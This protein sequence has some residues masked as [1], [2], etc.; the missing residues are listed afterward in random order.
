MKEKKK[1]RGL[2]IYTVDSSFVKNDFKILHSSFSITPF[3]FRPDR[4]KLRNVASL[5]AFL[6][7]HIWKSHFT[8]IWFASTHA[9]L[10]VLF[11]R[12]TG[13]KS[14]I[15]LGGYDVAHLPEL[16]YG[17]FSN[18][19]R[20]FTTRM[21][22]S[23]ATHNIAVSQFAKNKIT[24]RFPFLKKNTTVIY[25]CIDPEMYEQSGQKQKEDIVLTVALVDSEQR[26]RLKG[27]DSLLKVA[28]S[29][30]HIQFIVVG[31]APAIS[32]KLKPVPR[33]MQLIEPLPYSKLLD[34]YRRSKVYCLLSLTESFG[35]SVIEAMVNLC[36]PVV[37]NAGAL[38]ELVG[39]KGFLVDPADLD[40]ISR[41][42]VQAFHRYDQIVSGWETHRLF[43]AFSC[44]RRRKQLVHL[45]TTKTRR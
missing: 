41:S 14:F 24:Q 3:Q 25:N 33:N 16:Q 2:F 23:L 10:P 4:S 37:S 18:K 42:I 13:K 29:L 38:P 36:V 26:L 27:I 22:T 19:F 9:V 34:F 8:Y 11:S 15:V 6:G 21:A 31:V 32:R 28:S 7:K 5:F 45:I 39:D 1:F 20:T 35:M 12:L 43:T 40:E 30:P 44:D 17:T